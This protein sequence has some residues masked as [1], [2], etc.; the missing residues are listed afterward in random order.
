MLYEESA[1][2]G[3]DTFRRGVGAEKGLGLSLNF[4]RDLFNRGTEPRLTLLGAGILPKKTEKTEKFVATT[5]KRVRDLDSV[6][7]EGS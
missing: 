7:L 4:L 6:R 5:N 2:Q 3:L 1:G